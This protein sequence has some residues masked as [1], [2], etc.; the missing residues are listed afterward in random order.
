MTEKKG[1]FHGPGPACWQ[2]GPTSAL[3]PLQRPHGI[4]WVWGRNPSIESQRRQ[5]GGDRHQDKPWPMTTFK[6]KALEIKKKKK[7]LCAFVLE[8][9]SWTD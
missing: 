6:V 8:I 3:P 2:L 9:G 1:R 7:Y 5:D 4:V